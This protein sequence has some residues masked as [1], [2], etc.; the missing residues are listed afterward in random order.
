MACHNI[1]EF[2][3]YPGGS[4]LFMATLLKGWFPAARIFSLDTFEGMPE[5]LP[6]HDRHL[7]G[8]F[9]NADLA[10]FKARAADLELDNI[11]FVKG[12]MEHTFPRLAEDTKF[13][14]AHIDVD[15]YSAVRF[16]QEEV[17]PTLVAGGYLVYDDPTHWAC[18]GAAE[19]AEEFMIVRKIDMGP[20]TPSVI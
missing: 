20:E 15:I 16:A 10:S 7:P 14:L 17:W 4:V 13:G 19:A 2:G 8:D 5:T 3:S 11:C 12:R 9:A 18:H 6:S 1:V